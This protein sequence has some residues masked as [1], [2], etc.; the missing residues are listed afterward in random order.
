MNDYDDRA[1]PRYRPSLAPDASAAPGDAP[2][3]ASTPAGPRVAPASDRVVYPVLRLANLAELRVNEPVPVCYPD[4][5]SPGLLVKLG[6]PVENGT[7]PDRDV[8]AFSTQC[9]HRGNKLV[10]RADDKTLSCPGH[11]SRYDCERGGLLVWG[12]ATQNLPQFKLRVA[13]DGEIFAEGVDELIYG[14]TCNVLA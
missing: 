9:P 14:R 13:D 8:V 3:A 6:A 5:Q 2:A 1:E 10:Y 7:G 11:Y 4:E 12:H